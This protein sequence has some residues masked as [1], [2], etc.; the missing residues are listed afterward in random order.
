MMTA[1]RRDG[2]A[3]PVTGP[4]AP[5]LDSGPDPLAWHQLP[6]LPPGDVRRR[7]RMDL[8]SDGE[9]F[10]VNAMF[11]DSYRDDDGDESVIHEY[12]LE[13]RIRCDGLQV[14]ELR[15]E[16]RV[17]PWRECPVAQGS[18]QRLVGLPLG[19]L[20]AYVRKTLTGTS[21]CTHL[22]DLL[23]SLDD[24]PALVRA[25]KNGPAASV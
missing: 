25:L 4:P 24:V 19:S 1:L 13:A 12:G 3:P 21:T 23:R 17:L 9:I 18:A 20:R 15:P 10:L 7:R 22:N 8:A 6:V 2:T 14:L 16:A 11:R 5:D